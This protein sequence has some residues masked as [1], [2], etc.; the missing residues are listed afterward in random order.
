MGE[1]ATE[2]TDRR[3]PSFAWGGV[4]IVVLVQAAVLTVL[5]GG[6][7][8]HR[9]EFYFLAA[10]KRLAWGYV[11]QPPLTPALARVAAGLFGETP[12]GLR[13]VATL[14]GVATVV[15]LALVARELGGG[16]A[17]QVVTAVVTALSGYVLVVS[18]MLSTTTIDMLV[19]SVLGL[20]TVKLLK[21]GD[22]RWWLA[23]GAV[24]G[25][26]LLN[27]WLV[28]LLLVALAVAVGI[29]GPRK[30]F[31]T[32][33][34]AAG[35]VIAL[36]AVAPVLVWEAGHGWPMLTFAGDISG[37]DD[38]RLMFVPLQ[39]A[40]LSPVL[41]P[42]WIAGAVRLW[43]TP[44][45]R[46]LAL[47]YPIL[48][49][50][51]LALGGKPYYSLPLLMLL[52]AAG[53]QPALEWFGR[54]KARRWWL[55]AAAVGAV[56]SLAIGLPVVPTQALGPVLALNKEQGEQVGWPG[57]VT[58]VADAWRQV[59]DPATAVIFTSNYGEAGALEHAG[60]TAYS[61]HL[62]YGDWGP[63]PDRL[64][65]AVLLVGEFDRP[66]RAFTGCRQVA[67]QD[68]GID[69]D[70]QGTPVALCT[71]T[72]AGWSTLWRSLRHF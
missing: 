12:A 30:V 1:A 8:F 49:V 56:V 22:G 37:D 52:T 4:G 53:V 51:L 39:I 50:V 61:A 5:S 41:V 43:K 57:F 36:A 58:T 55:V 64:D 66:A 21:S 46:A 13:V 62:A 23:I 72:T 48:C 63:P 38:N 16:Y 20:L 65:G 35:A 45:L 25:V 15:V 3:T 70:E 19:W 69:N 67:V 47:A 17:A 44:R 14:A 34:L 18:H 9:D 26:G 11:D 40:Y 54:R 27:K 2:T 33:W 10:G 59:P 71:G 29:T 42:V 6:Y 7:G 24:T 32:W 60:I 68:T 28:P 31:R